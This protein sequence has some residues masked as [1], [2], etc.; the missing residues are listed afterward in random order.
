MLQSGN[1]RPKLLFGI[2][3]DWMLYVIL[4]HKKKKKLHSV[5][6]ESKKFK[7]Q[8]YMALKE[9]EPNM[10]AMNLAKEIKQKVK[11]ACQKYMKNTWREK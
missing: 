8:L 3:D 6:K 7:L 4:Q 2:I 5:A 9:N 11:L 1:Y 10:A